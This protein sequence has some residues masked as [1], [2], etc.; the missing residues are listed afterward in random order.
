MRP[1]YDRL[2]AVGKRHRVKRVERHEARC[3]AIARR[4]GLT[5]TPPS[6]VDRDDIMPRDFTPGGVTANDLMQIDETQDFRDNPGFLGDFPTGSVGRSLAGLDMATGK[7]PHARK[8]AFPAFT[9]QHCAVPENS[10]T[11]PETR[12]VGSLLHSDCHV[13]LPQGPRRQ[14]GAPKVICHEPGASRQPARQPL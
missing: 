7:T 8:S 14:L 12:P 1:P 5:A 4:H 13:T 9:Q 2:G 11:S 6:E 10:S 3:P